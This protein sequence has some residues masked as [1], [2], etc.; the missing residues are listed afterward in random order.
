MRKRKSTGVRLLTELI[1]ISPLPGTPP[2]PQGSIIVPESR[3]I[4][5]SVASGYFRQH[6]TI[7]QEA[8]AWIFDS[9]QSLENEGILYVFLVFHTELQL[10]C[11]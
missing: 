2:A 7:W 4:A 8:P 5:L 11:I 1:G 10:G 9:I 6:R 3:F